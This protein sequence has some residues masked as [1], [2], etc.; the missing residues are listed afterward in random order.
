MQDHLFLI[1]LDHE[2]RWFR[3]HQLFTDLLQTYLVREYSKEQIAALHR[4]ASNWFENAGE[5]DRAINYAISGNDFERAA[6]LIEERIDHVMSRGRLRTLLRWIDVLPEELLPS[7]PRLRLYQA[8]ALSL[9]GQ[10]ERAEQILINTKSKLKYLPDTAENRALRG[11]LAGLLAG[12]ITYSNDPPRIIREAQEAL[13]FLPEDHM[14]S[15]ARV[16]IA[17]GTGYAYD[18]EMGKARDSY[19]NARRLALKAKN[20]FLA[21]AALEMLA[22]IQ[23][24]HL[25]HLKDSAEILGQILE[26]GRIDGDTYHPFAGTAH[27]LLAEINLEWN[28]LD[29]VNDYLKSGTKLLQQGGISYSLTYVHTLRARLAL[30]RGET[31]QVVAALHAAKRA[32]QASPLMHILIHN[33][34]RQVKHWLYLGDIAAATQWAD[35]D[36]AVLDIEIPESLPTYL[37]EVHQIS[38]AR[39][40]LSQGEINL[41]IDTL[42]DVLTSAEKAGR[43]GHVLESCLLKA[44]ALSKKGE[45]KKVSKY[46]EYA[47]SLAEPEQFVRLFLDEGDP[48][49]V[50]LQFAESQGIHIPYVSRLLSLF[51]KEPEQIT[52]DADGTPKEDGL[53]DRLT[54]REMDV[55]RLLCEGYS[56]K[57]IAVDLTVSINT[58]KKHTSTIYSKL[59][60]RNRAQAALRARELG[61]V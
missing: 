21:T 1:P 60:V 30:A 14:A 61:L 59:G 8:W 51:D 11:E 38:L 42:N 45:S 52:T 25:G 23:I 24:Y 28:E 7:R 6:D 19:L 2:N 46:L 41:T 58:V 31:D 39:V 17:L 16:L 22:G 18:D 32:A 33:L 44:L 54:P 37:R 12:I 9:G 27:I 57:Q 49:R 40:Y 15:R 5:S 29:K 34:S 4:R 47:L 55:L 53:F 20:Q 3:Y 50:L 48:A 26:L 35:G 13:T 56:N 10:S 36:P 43:I